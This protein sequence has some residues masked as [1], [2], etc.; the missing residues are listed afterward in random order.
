MDATW[1]GVIGSVGGTLLGT[2]VGWLLARVHIGALKVSLS[3][4]EN[5]AMQ[6]RM[7]KTGHSTLRSPFELYYSG[8][9]SMHVYNEGDACKTMRKPNLLLCNKDGKELARIDLYD[10]NTFTEI[11]FNASMVKLGT[12]NIEGRTGKDYNLLF[13]SEKILTFNDAKELFFCY[14]NERGKEKKFLIED[15]FDIDKRLK[16]QNNG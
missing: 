5:C 13:Y 3:H 12:L 8:T 6:K 7:I 2:I 16:E 11:D 9:F 14:T 4:V 1:I 10:D 15:N